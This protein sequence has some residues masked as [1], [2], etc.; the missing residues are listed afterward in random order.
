MP[1]GDELSVRVAAQT[2]DFESGIE[3]ARDELTQFTADTAQASGGLQVLQGR[4]DEAEDEISSVGRSATTASFGL[5]QLSTSATGSSISLSGLGSTLLV[6]VIPALVATSAAL[7]PVVTA[8]GGLAAVLGAIGFT[9][10]VGGLGAVTTNTE[11]LRQTFKQ[12][13]R[14]LET[15]LEPLFDAFTTVL[16]DVGDAFIDI[17]P[18]LVPAE[19]Q[20]ENIAD[21]F[22]ELGLTAVDALPALV[23]L[24]TTLTTEFLPA[25][26][27]IVDDI[28]G[29]LPGFLETLVS[30]FRELSGAFAQTATF[31]VELGP[32]LLEFGFTMLDVVGPA[33]EFVGDVLLTGIQRFNNLDSSLQ[34][35]LT[36]TS[37]VAPVLA[38]LVS[39]VGGPLTIAIGAIIAS[40]TVFREETVALAETI[41]G[42]AQ[43][44]FETLLG[45]VGDLD[46][47][48]LMDSVEGLQEAV[49]D[50]G[51]VLQE[52]FNT[53]LDD[54]GTA[55]AAN[56]GPITDFGQ[57]LADAFTGFIDVLEGLQPV[58]QFVLTNVVVPILGEL[59]TL[60]QNQLGPTLNAIGTAIDNWG[61]ILNEVG[62]VLTEFYNQNEEQ[63]IPTVE[64]LADVVGLGLVNAFDT[65]LTTI[66]IVA[67]LFSGDLGGAFLELAGLFQRFRTRFT[68]L[69]NGWNVVE[70]LQGI[71][72]DIQTGFANFFTQ[73]LPGLIIAGLGQGLGLIRNILTDIQNAFIAAFNSIITGVAGLMT[74]LVNT[75]VI[76]PLNSLISTINN[77]IT[78]LP[79]D[80]QAE[81]PGLSQQAEL[82]T[83]DV[84]AAT[85]EQQA[86]NAQQTVSESTQEVAASL[87]IDIS[88]D[89]QLAEII[90]ENAEIAIESTTQ[91]AERLGQRGG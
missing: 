85:I 54:L 86:T 64:F 26:T 14:T 24:A 89:S 77:V 21:G 28:A 27:D 59:I 71:I 61:T 11:E 1:F 29:G 88:G 13:K 47:S 62:T 52:S 8:L 25:L 40:V 22:R 46:L 31:L 79:D 82:Q 30:T 69:I 53:V 3:S 91:R 81:L 63:I 66:R 17:I 42:I 41:Q 51:E 37:S 56:R 68:R 20:I 19:E 10:F 45:V 72:S 9:G 58:I 34:N 6:S 36:T 15:E 49:G 70:V 35:L 5:G 4:A 67:E 87:N 57:T 65:L 23:E 90:Q 39:V 12:I 48:D 84:S 44:A 50:T 78:Q 74:E 2:R 7:I 55:I 60:L 83:P 38:A 32:E 73:T 33:I 75:A 80:V 43:D 18:S 76:D 16:N